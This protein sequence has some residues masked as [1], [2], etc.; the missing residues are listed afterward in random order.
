VVVSA[1]VSA[2]G[3]TLGPVSVLVIDKTF[4]LFDRQRKGP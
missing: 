2:P 1:V 3:L 4:V